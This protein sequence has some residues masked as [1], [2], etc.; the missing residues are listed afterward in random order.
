MTEL[1][2][3]GPTIDRLYELREKR[4]ELERRAKDLKSEEFSL[5]QEIIVLLGTAGLDKASGHNAT[6]SLKTAMMPMV[7]DWDLVFSY[8]RDNDRFDLLQK[9]LSTLAWRDL[10]EAGSLVPG[11]EAVEDVDISLTKSSRG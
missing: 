8:V 5:R 1:N 3:L 10:N 11:T 2:K 4:L 7:T 9:R 6:A